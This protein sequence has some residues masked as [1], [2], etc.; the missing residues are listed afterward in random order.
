V[1][2][3]DGED[4][5]AGVPECDDEDPHPTIVVMTTADTSP[6]KIRRLKE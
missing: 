3:P 1:T 2:A 4:D 6:P 5:V